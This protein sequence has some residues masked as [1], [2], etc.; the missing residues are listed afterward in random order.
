MERA[1]PN[2]G[3]E[4]A[5]FQNSIHLPTNPMLTSLEKEEELARKKFLAHSNNADTW[6]S[7]RPY[8]QLILS[9]VEKYTLNEEQT[10]AFLIFA[11]H[12]G[13]KYEMHEKLKPLRM[14][15]GGPGGAGKSQVF[16]AI[17][18]FY[19]LL[20]HET[21]LKI[22]APTGLA[23][24]NV[25]GATIH[26]EASLRVEYATMHSGSKHGQACRTNLEEKWLSITAH[27]SDEIYFLGVLD[28][29]QMSQYLQLAKQVIEED[30]ILGNLDT[31]F[32]GDPAQLPAHN[33]TSL[34]DHE[35]VKSH[36]TRKLNG[37]MG[38]INRWLKEW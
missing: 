5:G 27:I 14:I 13:R 26:A 1:M 18:E 3:P 6:N 25:G 11:D 19:I 21:Q 2:S 34:Y 22:T 37:L 33:A 32:A 9:L 35:L 30:V 20:G 31:L 15:L 12:H 29:A 4:G 38:Y 10:L 24:N 16:D 36:T 7:L 28:F 8:Q 17:R 23:A